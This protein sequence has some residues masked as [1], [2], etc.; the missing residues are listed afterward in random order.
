MGLSQIFKDVQ[1][2]Q[3]NC[4]SDNLNYSLI[5]GFFF[6]VYNFFMRRTSY[7][8]VLLKSVLTGPVNSARDPHRNIGCSLQIISLLSNTYTQAQLVFFSLK[9]TRLELLDFKAGFG[10]R[11][12]F[13]FKSQALKQ[14]V[15]CTIHET[16]KPLFS[17]KLY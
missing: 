2:C 13:G 14:W 8:L 9:P 3:Q 7:R 5:V 12:A 11:L 17:A 15:S 4:I 16:H 10:Q 6:I 1:H